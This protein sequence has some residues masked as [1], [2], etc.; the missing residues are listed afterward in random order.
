VTTADPKS[1]NHAAKR[2]AILDGAAEVFATRGFVAGTTTEIG[3]KVGLSQSAIYHYVGSKSHLL[4]EIAL[5]MDD[6]M[7]SALERGL[8]ASEEPAAQ[9]VAIITEF[10]RA[11]IRFRWSFSVYWKE[12]HLLPVDVRRKVEKDERRFVGAVEALFARLQDGGD[13]P[14]GISPTIATKGI[15]G[16]VSWVYQ[17]YRPTGQFDADEIADGFV[18]LIGLNGVTSGAT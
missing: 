9:M 18:R 12:Q 2:L 3:Q 4:Q 10:T 11:V 1:E 14:A 8:G 5:H 13:I 15:L 17:W 6:E 7:N 16:M